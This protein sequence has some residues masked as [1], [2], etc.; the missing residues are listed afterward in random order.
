MAFRKGVIT[1]MAGMA[2]AYAVQQKKRAEAWG[3]NN[4]DSYPPHGLSKVILLEYVKD[5]S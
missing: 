4:S 3:E 2:G 1:S 5:G